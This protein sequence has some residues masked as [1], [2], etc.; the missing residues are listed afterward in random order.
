MLR[1]NQ[2]TFP[3]SL[4]LRNLI[5]VSCR[6]AQSLSLVTYGPSLPTACYRIFAREQSNFGTFRIIRLSSLLRSTESYTKSPAQ[7]ATDS[8]IEM[9]SD[10]RYGEVVTP[11]ALMSQRIRRVLP[12]TSNQ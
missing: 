4:N 9:R 7:R 1:K 12:F 3:T 8:L 10:E 2:K 11:F 5:F 6:C